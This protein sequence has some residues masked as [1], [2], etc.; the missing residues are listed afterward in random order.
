MKKEIIK[1]FDL[2]KAK[3]G[4]KLRTRC[5][6]PV[7]IFIWNSNSPFP[8]KGII[9]KRLE[10]IAS[11][12]NIYGIWCGSSNG[13]LDLVIVEEVE[14]V[15]EPKFWS[16]DVENI[17]KGFYIEEPSNI[18]DVHSI[19][20]TEANYNVFATEKQAKSAL[21]M[22]R[23]SQIMA[24]DIKNFGGVIT[25][26]EWENDEK[27]YVIYRYGSHINT[28]STM[29]NSYYFLA[30]HT[31]QQRNLFLEKYPQLVHDFLMI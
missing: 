9:S 25:D 2:A 16:D 1:P 22:A 21:A 29:I 23:I 3:A 24:N 4:A 15:E 5:G 30:F 31:A 14:E 26:E 12:W 7:E 6:C 10:D 28:T 18:L 8:I 13:D 19:R 27:K 17:F 11:E 20:N